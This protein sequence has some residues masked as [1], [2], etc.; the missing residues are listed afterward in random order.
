MRRKN[1]TKYFKINK[2]SL[3]K[4]AKS[5]L[6]S[7]IIEA[8]RSL[9][10]ERYESEELFVQTVKNVIGVAN[11]VKYGLEITQKSTKYHRKKSKKKD[12]RLPE[13]QL[14]QSGKVEITA[15][16]GMFL[17][18]ELIKKTEMIESFTAWASF[19]A[20]RSPRRLIY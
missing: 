2:G 9:L 20:R 17:L 12:V 19:F 11:F 16:G 6:P 8:L 13:Y 7:D 4:L 10:N 15:N 1:R 14:E 5:G 18:A 3:E